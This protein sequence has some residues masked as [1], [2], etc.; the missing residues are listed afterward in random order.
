MCLMLDIYK[1]KLNGTANLAPRKN[2]L[3]LTCL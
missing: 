1:K 3:E 2:L